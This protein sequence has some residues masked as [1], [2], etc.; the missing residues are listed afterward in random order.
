MSLEAFLISSVPRTARCILMIPTLTCAG[1]RAGKMRPAANTART[2]KNEK[3]D[4]AERGSFRYLSSS[5]AG[6][7]IARNRGGGKPADRAAVRSILRRGGGLAP[8]GFELAFHAG[9]FLGTH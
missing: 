1:A 6:A 4:M 3:R 5:V 9:D 8:G 7:S 2:G